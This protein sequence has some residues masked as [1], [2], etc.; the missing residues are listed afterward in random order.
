MFLKLKK[1]EKNSLKNGIFISE[2]NGDCKELTARGGGLWF[3][4][5]YSN[6]KNMYIITC[7]DFEFTIFKVLKKFY[8]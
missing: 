8:F 4:V 5:K 7:T 6:L 3:F 2:P 1:S